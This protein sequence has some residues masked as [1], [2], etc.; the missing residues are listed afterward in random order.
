[1]MRVLLLGLIGLLAGC[2]YTAGPL[3]PE[4]VRRIAVPIAQNESL[5]RH[6]EVTYT[7]ELKQELLRRSGA[8][9][10]DRGEADAILETRIVEVPRNALVEDAVDQILE[11]AILVR[12][13][14]RLY[15]PRDGVDLVPPFE[16]ARRAERIVPRGETIATA[17]DEALRDVAR[18]TVLRI[19]ADP[20]LRR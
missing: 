9:V 7:R 12:V 11:D 3:L 19:E 18:E 10:V 20:F 1:M 4:G 2:G 14:V 15:D 16:V 5:Y 8:R 6:A 13:A 17:I